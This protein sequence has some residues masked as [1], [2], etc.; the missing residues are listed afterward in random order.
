MNIEVRNQPARNIYFGLII[1]TDFMF[2]SLKFMIILDWMQI[3]LK[4]FLLV[5]KFEVCETVDMT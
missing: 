1:G 2:E 3:F 4:I 5:Q